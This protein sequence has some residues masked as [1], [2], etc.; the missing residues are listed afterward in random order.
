MQRPKNSIIG[1]RKGSSNIWEPFWP[2]PITL[3]VTIN[4]QSHLTILWTVYK[5]LDSSKNVRSAAN[6]SEV[7]IICG[8]KLFV[9]LICRLLLIFS[10]KLIDFRAMSLK[11]KYN[12]Q[13][14][15]SLDGTSVKHFLNGMRIALISCLTSLFF[16]ANT[17]K[18]F[19]C[20]KSG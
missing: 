15:C 12:W 17:S 13:M 18:T 3:S 1:N 16:I 2:I 8:V 4:F 20:T 14:Q 5:T 7:V 6:F 19:F 11:L 9:T 10:V